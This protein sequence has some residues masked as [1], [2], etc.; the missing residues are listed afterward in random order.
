MVGL[1]YGGPVPVDH[2]LQQVRR[3]ADLPE[4]IRALGHSPAWEPI[5]SSYWPE[6]SRLALPENQS[7]RIGQAGELPW[8]GIAGPGARVLARA[9]AQIL[10]KRGEP[11]ALIAL[12][13]TT[14]ELV[15]SVAFGA[16]PSLRIHPDRLDGGTRES[17]DRLTRIRREGRLATAAQVAAALSEEGIGARFFAAFKDQ[18]ERLAQSTRLPTGREDRR[19]LA[20]LQLN[21][22]LFLYFVQSRGWLDSRPDFLRREVDRCLARRGRLHQQLLKPL[23]F[24]TL[25]RRPDHRSPMAA[26]LGRIPFLN[27]GLF[28]PHRLERG[29]PGFPNPI[30]RDAFDDLFERF[31]FTVVEGSTTAIAPD[32]LGRV[33]EGLMAPGDRGLSGTF[34]TPPRLVRTVIDE[35]L[36]ALV[37][38]RFGWDPGKAENA[39]ERRD[40]RVV[41]L[42]RD[43]TVLDPAAGSGAFLLG[44]LDRLLEIR[45]GHGIARHRLSREILQKNLFGVDINPT[46]VRLTE[47]RLWLAV[48]AADPA[49][50][51]EA[52]SPL[53]NL[54][55]LV[56]QGDSLA[57]PLNL[58]TRFPFRGGAMGGTLTRLRRALI[59]ATGE[60]KRA[61]AKQL[62]QAEIAAMGECL[63]FAESSVERG[64][65]ECLLSARTCDLFGTARGL[66][67]SLRA[68]LHGWR[69]WRSRI[70]RVRQRLEKDG[71]VPWFQ[72][73]SHFA[74]VIGRG[75]F[76]AVVGNPPW[77]RAEDIPSQVRE[78]LAN[79]YQW[80]RSTG[81]GSGGGFR[82][83]PDLAVAFLERATELTRPGGVVGLLLPAKVATASYGAA[84]R[85]GLGRDYSIH[86][87]SDLSA[88]ASHDFDATVYPLALVARKSA[89][90]AEHGMTVRYARGT[91]RVRQSEFTQGGQWIVHSSDAAAVARALRRRFPGVGERF[92]IHLGVKTGANQVFLDPPTD[93]E[94]ELV[95]RALRGRDLRPFGIRGS[96]RMLWPC[97]SNGTPLARLPFRTREYLRPFEPLLRARKDFQDGAYWM[98]F[99]TAPVAARYRVIWPDLARRLTAVALASEPEQ[100]FIPLNTCYLL[101]AP[102]ASAAYAMTAWFNAT[103]LRA[104]ARL[105]A[106]PARGGYVRY[107]ARAVAG[108]PLPPG[109]LDD[110]D[111]AAAGK[112]AHQDPART[113]NI[114]ELAATHLQ[115]SSEARRVLARVAEEGTDSR[116]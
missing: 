82:H 42:V 96:T 7:A 86:S 1:L 97:E 36:V 91:S 113:E 69:T 40:A 67:Q 23:F 31:H 8:I 55:S 16:R 74:D 87:V 115:L 45:S 77:V 19:A 59:G 17:F 49:E 99:R 6:R 80:W 62:R 30:L 76:D 27:G 60:D 2:P 75:G 108:L 15:L 107:N 32:M 4:L 39:L 3:C 34:Y 5:P 56:R 46:A 12:D 81:S 98:L 100:G 94:P 79:R 54:D 10:Q 21:R 92:P 44:T 84:A 101:A 29:W 111:L 116:R 35:C 83:Q 14:G 52:V 102:T 57:D 11:A 90:S 18:L 104:L 93:L 70:R 41:G 63:A 20:L 64:M 37:V 33:F 73:E 88:E 66:D 65:R 26:S 95:R 68:E 58:V 48:I 112:R 50:T 78:A 85:R 9:A 22:L 103:W 43:L 47:L 114:D 106:D 38:E 105:G 51:A 89:P 109:I 110:P 28:D 72:F 13:L 25:N 53:P 71:E 24:G 61:A